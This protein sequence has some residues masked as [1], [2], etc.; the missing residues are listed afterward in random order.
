MAI[1]R[2]GSPQGTAASLRPRQ[3]VHQR[4]LPALLDRPWHRL[5]HEPQGDCWDN[6]VMESF[7]STLR[8]REPRRATTPPA[9]THA[10]TCSATSS[11]STTQCDSRCY[12]PRLCSNQRCSGKRGQPPLNAMRAQGSTVPRRARFQLI[13]EA[14]SPTG[15]S[16]EKGQDYRV[17]DFSSIYYLGSRFLRE[18]ITNPATTRASRIR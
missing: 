8:R 1:W 7:F 14:V 11:G 3:P 13:S 5:Q 4:R 17:I 16:E 10:R 9:I 15:I 2:R 6:A 18:L 12:T